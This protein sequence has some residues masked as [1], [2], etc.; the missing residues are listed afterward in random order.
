[1]LV[2]WTVEEE[3]SGGDKLK[4]SLLFNLPDLRQAVVVVVLRTLSSEL[5]PVSSNSLTLAIAN[6][7]PQSFVPST[8][9]IFH[10]STSHKENSTG[11]TLY[12]FLTRCPAN[13][14]TMMMMMMIPFH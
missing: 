13:S 12:T 11:F 10:P 9:P 3:G 4:L 8:H 6:L 2:F 1:M 7:L 5:H 14:P